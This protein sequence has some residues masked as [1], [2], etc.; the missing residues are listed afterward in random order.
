MKKKMV[1]V[2][3]ENAS[4][5]GVK[6]PPEFLADLKSRFPDIVFTESLNDIATADAMFSW[7]ITAPALKK[8]KKLKWFHTAGVQ[9]GHLFPKNLYKKAKV[10]N[11]RGVWGEYVAEQFFGLLGSFMDVSFLEGLVAGVIGLG[12]IGSE[13]AKH[14][15]GLKMEVV[16]TKLHPSINSEAADK[17]FSPAQLDK[18]LKISDVVF[19][20]VPLTVKTRRLLGKKQFGSMK[21]GAYLLTSAR[22][23][24]IDERALKEAVRSGKISGAV[25]DDMMP[26]EL[27]KEEGIVAMPHATPERYNIWPKMFQV[28]AENLDRFANG[29]PLVNRMDPCKRLY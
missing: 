10:T 13:V 22:R 20:T 25:V 28:F 11:S 1:L 24:V 9:Y 21:T 8:A 18:L 15:K 17:I 7:S 12:G 14:A 26:K 16:A 2:N 23:G 27:L 3:L 6:P 5:P 19:V 29:K 4:F